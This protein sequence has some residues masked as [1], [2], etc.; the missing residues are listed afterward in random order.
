MNNLNVNYNNISSREAEGMFLTRIFS[1]KLTKLQSLMDKINGQIGAMNHL[2]GSSLISMLTMVTMLI[3]SVFVHEYSHMIAARALFLDVNPYMSCDFSKFECH[4]NYATTKVP[5]DS[6]IG[7][8]FRQGVVDAAGPISDMTIVALS[9]IIAWKMRHSNKKISFMFAATACV[10][11]WNAFYYAASTLGSDHGDYARMESNLGI[12]HI[13]QTAIVGSVALGT[14][15]LMKHI[16]FSDSINR[17]PKNTRRV[18]LLIVISK[19][20]YQRNLKA[21]KRFCQ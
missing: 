4:A 17:R 5:P 7:F 2:K 3:G 10:I 16:L 12:S 15:M 21:R 13:I 11:A 1:S 14:T 19:R 18:R 9:S 6:N 8:E 20:H